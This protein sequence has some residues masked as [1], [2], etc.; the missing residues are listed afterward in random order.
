MGTL[1]MF[2]GAPLIGREV[3]W[4]SPLND[5]P[6]LVHGLAVLTSSLANELN[7][8][9]QSV[10][11]GTQGIMVLSGCRG[12]LFALT[13]RGCI[14]IISG[15]AYL[16]FAFAIECIRAR[17]FGSCFFPSGGWIKPASANTST[18]APQTL[19]R[20][21]RSTVC[22]SR[23]SCSGTG[24]GGARRHQSGARGLSTV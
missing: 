18:S 22:L 11:F 2:R 13:P 12:Q 1:S 19:Q 9:R 10:D 17:I 14:R 6:E 8:E 23:T 5:V 21:I 16:M 7:L 15:V 20:R 24:I 4:A 3:G